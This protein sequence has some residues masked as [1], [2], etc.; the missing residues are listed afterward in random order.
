MHKYDIDNAQVWLV[1]HYPGCQDVYGCVVMYE[2]PQRAMLPLIE[3]ITGAY[4][5][6]N[7]VNITEVDLSTLFKIRQNYD[8]CRYKYSVMIYGNPNLTR[9]MFHPTLCEIKGEEVFIRA[10]KNLRIENVTGAPFP[11]DI[12]SKTDCSLKMARDGEDCFSLVGEF[13][14]NDS[15]E[16]AQIWPNIRK[17]Y[18]TITIVNTSL[19]DLNP[20]RNVR[21]IDGW[22]SPALTI[23]NNSRLIDISA[24]MYTQIIGP[25]PTSVVENNPNLC[26]TA[27]KRRRLEKKYGKLKWSRKCLRKCK[28]G[29]VNEEYVLSLGMMC[30]EIDGDLIFRNLKKDTAEFQRLRRI[31]RL[32]G[33][34][35]IE[36]TT[37]LPDVIF[38]DH[39]EEINNPD[40]RQPSLKV[41]NME[42]FKLQGLD[43]LRKIHGDVEVATQRASDVPDNVREQLKKACDGKVTFSIVTT[44]TAATTPPTAMETDAAKRS[45]SNIGNSE[46][47][48]SAQ[49]PPRE[50]TS[51]QPWMP[52]GARRSED[53]H[54]EPET[55]SSSTMIIVV[56]IVIVVVVIVLV[57][58][59]LIIARHFRQKKMAA[60]KEKPKSKTPTGKSPASATPTQDTKS[61]A[62]QD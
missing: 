48:D 10:N 9:I 23:V 29:V 28:G 39:L 35:I 7:L 59:A 11:V 41:S 26:Q 2:G 12:G 31:D 50:G 51:L 18:G 22:S 24:L 44:T 17:V 4:I 15:Y 16:L 33:R 53:E 49:P 21:I 32:N 38:L 42:N 56:V 8:N 30:G 55:S 40:T 60:S 37:I 1:K 3:N 57:V 36:N 54:T 52:A 6:P 20:L 5:V 46:I 19:T 62:K 47:S 45:E 13:M 27:E 14:L 34:L 25:K 43:S 61:Q 58:A